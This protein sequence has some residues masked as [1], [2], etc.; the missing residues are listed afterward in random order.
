M[1]SDRL[2]FGTGNFTIEAWIYPP[3]AASQSPNFYHSIFANSNNTTGLYFSDNGNNYELFFG[4][5]ST[6]YAVATPGAGAI[7][8]SQ[9]N[10]VFF[11]RSGGVTR[12][13]VNGIVYP[14]QNFEG[15]VNFNN[16]RIGGLA[17]RGLIDSVRVSNSGI[18]PNTSPYTQPTGEFD[19]ASAP[20]EFVVIGYSKDE[21]VRL[22]FSELNL[23]EG[24]YFLTNDQ[25]IFK[26]QY[27]FPILAVN[28]N[29][30]MK[31]FN[32]SISNMTSRPYRGE[33]PTAIFTGTVPQ[34]VDIDLNTA[35]QY[36][37]TLA[38]PIGEFSSPLGGTDAGSYWTFTGTK[39]QLNSLIS[40]I[41]FTSNDIA[42]S[43]STYTYSLEKNGVVLVNKERTLQGVL[44]ALGALGPTGKAFPRLNLTIGGN[45]TINEAFTLTAV[46]STST[47]LRGTLQFKEGNTVFSSTQ[48]SSSGTAITTVNYAT[49]GSRSL[50]VSW[51][52]DEL[53]N[54]F[55]YE[56]L[57]S[58][59]TRI[60]VDTAAKLPGNVVASVENI[61]S[62]RVPAGPEITL[63]GELP[64]TFDFGG[65]VTFKSIV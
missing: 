62:L 34:V 13:G 50:S 24:E 59:D 27:N 38:S 42:N 22:T 44:L 8:H 45:T 51:L 29:S 53:I 40:S 52:A 11:Q 9:W 18:Y 2:N 60:F 48:I 55:A 56:P 43:N 28:D 39:S 12:M 46:I 47:Q 21:K 30:E 31:W 1:T 5:Q 26:D 16:F 20:G 41:V 25:G 6:N 32:T 37:F 10:H 14:V 3:L 7:R 58:F 17:A 33:Q 19:T 65:I 15:S 35:T 36:T 61:P 4:H 49:T 63:V 54:N 57:D 64:G 23:P